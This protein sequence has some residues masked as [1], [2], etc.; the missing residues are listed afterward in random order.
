M[1]HIDVL[2]GRANWH[3]EHAPRA[4]DVLRALPA[5]SVDVI[6]TDPPYATTGESTAWVSKDKVRSLPRETQFY[7]A[8]IRE[9]LAE[10]R[11][12]LKPTGGIWMSCDWAAA[13]AIDQACP[14][15]GLRAPTIGVWDREGLGMGYVLRH[16]YECFAVITMPEWERIYT[17]EPDVWRCKWTPSDRTMGHSAEKPVPLMAR[18]IRLLARPGGVALD[19]FSGSGTTGVAALREGLRYIGIERDDG[20]VV[21]QRDRLSAEQM[22]SDVKAK[23]SGQEA[24]NF[25]GSQ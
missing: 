9:Y 8:W 2:E 5:A 10:F 18:A 11:R 3:V 14:R 22:G 6:P 17:D 1:S 4:M 13:M 21:L 12:I 7:E 24:L 15:V 25:G 16:V 23:R 20:F 19:P